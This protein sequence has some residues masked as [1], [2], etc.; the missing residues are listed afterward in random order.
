LVAEAEAG[1]LKMVLLAV[2]A[3]A[4][5]VLVQQQ[6]A[7]LELLGKEMLVEII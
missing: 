6:Q 1:I 7:A 5:A 3:V 4:V 2:L